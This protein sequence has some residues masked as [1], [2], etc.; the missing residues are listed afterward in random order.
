MEN[1]PDPLTNKR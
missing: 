1:F